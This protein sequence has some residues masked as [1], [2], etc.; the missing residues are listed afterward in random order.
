M[1]TDTL[2]AAI[3]A[4]LRDWFE[5]SGLT[6]SQRALAAGCGVSAARMNAVLRELAAAGIVS[7]ASGPAGTCI[8]IK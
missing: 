1:S 5:A 6:G 4:G 2:E 8:S 3:K 7:V